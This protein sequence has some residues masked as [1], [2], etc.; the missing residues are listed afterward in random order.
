MVGDQLQTTSSGRNMMV[1]IG[2]LGGKNSHKLSTT[3]FILNTEN[4]YKPWNVL[5]VSV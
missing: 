5:L 4:T 3:K 1:K 2:Y